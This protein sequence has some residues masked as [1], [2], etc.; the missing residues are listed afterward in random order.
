M[1][2][3]SGDDLTLFSEQKSQST[4]GPRTLGCS[5]VFEEFFFI[6][7]GSQ[8]LTSLPATRI[9]DNLLILF[10]DRDGVG[11]GFQS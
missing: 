2:L 9:P 6:A 1:G 4:L 8:G 5:S 10:I 3:V 7:F 11:V